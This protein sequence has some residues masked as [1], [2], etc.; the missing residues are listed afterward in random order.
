MKKYSYLAMAL[1]VP[2]ALSGCDSSTD[3]EIGGGG[4]GDGGGGDG[5][6]AEL[7]GNTFDAAGFALVHNTGNQVAAEQVSLDRT[8]TSAQRFGPP[9]AQMHYG[10]D[11]LVK[12]VEIGI[13]HPIEVPEDEEAA[14]GISLGYQTVK[15]FQNMDEHSCYVQEAVTTASHLI[16]K[17]D[18]YD[19]ADANGERLDNCRLIGLPLES[20]HAAPQC[21]LV[22][23]AHDE[24]GN[25]YMQQ[26]NP[27][28]L[29]S[30]LDGQYFVFAHN[31]P[32]L[33]TS[34]LLQTSVSQ[35]DGH[36]DV[37]AVFNY[38]LEHPS[39]TYSAPINHWSKDGQFHAMHL[40]YNAT[41]MAKHLG[42]DVE[43][44]RGLNYY[45]NGLYGEWLTLGDQ[46]VT[47]YYA[48]SDHDRPEYLGNLV[49]NLADGSHSFQRFSNDNG[50]CDFRGCGGLQ[51]V[52]A[53]QIV[54]T[55]THAYVQIG[56]SFNDHSWGFFHF[57]PDSLQAT[58]LHI[59][60]E[61][62]ERAPS[63]NRVGD[64]H[65]AFLPRSEEFSL[66]HMS[67]FDM[68]SGLYHGENLLDDPL[69]DRSLNISYRTNTNGLKFVVNYLDGSAKEIFYNQVTGEFTEDPIDHQEIGATIP[70]MPSS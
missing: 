36:G 55:G 27:S 34:E 49:F 13:Q 3:D 7:I 69:F 12:L 28:Y 15:V 30:S 1:A 17:G 32:R 18:F 39:H 31:F 48:E 45:N 68:H 56:H 26:A 52:V 22:A 14:E 51:H 21:L 19:L 58:E 65:L 53:T 37:E 47:F 24:D 5:S 63:F 59:P 62:H 54:D 61:N 11:Q 41:M 67:Y 20:K 4:P 29:K 16:L 25:W 6:V 38:Q 9:E 50:D 64:T 70:L 42:Q 2:L 33:D 43:V 60:Q 10:C 35:W 66:T 57:D 8:A 23:D 44:F 40:G 46:L